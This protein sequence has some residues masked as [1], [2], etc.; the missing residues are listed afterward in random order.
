MLLFGADSHPN[1]EMNG[2]AKMMDCDGILS[3]IPPT[4][5]TQL[6]LLSSLL[7]Q[8]GDLQSAGEDLG[9]VC[10]SD[11]LGSNAGIAA[12]T[13][14]CAPAQCCQT[15]NFGDGCG[16]FA[17]LSYEPCLN[18]GDIVGVDFPPEAGAVVGDQDADADADA[19]ADQDDEGEMDMTTGD[20]S[21]T[22]T[23]D[24]GPTGDGTFNDPEQGSLMDKLSDMGDAVKDTLK[25]ATTDPSSL[26]TGEMVGLA[27]GCFVIFMILVCLIKCCCKKKAA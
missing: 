2:E 12:C 23:T 14:A 1:F 21:G 25:K 8:Q 15:G 22:N 16:V 3:I 5:L 24:T 18:L 6:A 13:E 4:N 20:D 26:S 9:V 7:L 11:N 27:I 10:S 17:C 19:D